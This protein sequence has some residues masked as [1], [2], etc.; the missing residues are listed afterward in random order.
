MGGVV[1][2]LWAVMS[3]ARGG[4]SAASGN[5]HTRHAARHKSFAFEVVINFPP[6]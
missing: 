6:Y 2:I 1:P 3:S 5:A 4:C